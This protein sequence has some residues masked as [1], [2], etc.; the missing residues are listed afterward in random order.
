MVEGKGFITMHGADVTANHRTYVLK[1]SGLIPSSKTLK[2]L[3]KP[4]TRLEKLNPSH[5]F[6]NRLESITLKPATWQNI[7]VIIGFQKKKNA[8]INTGNDNSCSL[9]NIRVHFNKLIEHFFF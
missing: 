9:E 8:K 7:Y 1:T 6:R 5:K 4:P 3:K 2:G